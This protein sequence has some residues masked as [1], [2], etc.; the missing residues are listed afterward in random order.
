MLDTIPSL[1]LKV[2]RFPGGEW[3]DLNTITKTQIDT[4]VA[5]A[6]QWG[7]EPMVN[8]RLPNSTPADAVELLRYA[9][10]E[11]GYNIRFWAI[12]NE[13]NLYAGRTEMRLPGY[14]AEQ[15]ATDWRFFAQAMKATDPSITLV[16]PEISQF[17]PNPTAEYGQEFKDWLVT[18]LK[19]NGDLVDIVSVHRYPYPQSFMSGPPS[20]ADLRANSAEWDILIPSLHKIVRE[21]TGRDLPVAVTEFNS[22]WAANAGGEGTMDSHFN[23]VWFTDVMGRMIKHDTFMLQQFAISGNFGLMGRSELNS[24][25]LAYVMFSRFGNQRIYAS[26]DQ[27]YVTVY[28]AKRPDGALTIMVINLNS[29]P[30][31]V[32]LQIENFNGGQAEVWKLDLQYRAEQVTAQQLTA[33]N[34]LSLSPESVTLFILPGR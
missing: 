24:T 5:F 27:Q 28:A 1:G 20:K 13:P 19:V 2:V 4:L 6:R 32:N 33:I 22:S 8:V 11:K 34:T 23:G 3:G 10:I 15:F 14:A 30:K 16:G 18:F 21:H 26:S 12:G 29:E 7:A 9:N 17:V 31:S 25:G